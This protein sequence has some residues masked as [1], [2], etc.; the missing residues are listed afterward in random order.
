MTPTQNS[1]FPPK[2]SKFPLR[3]NSP[4]LGTTALEFSAEN[5]PTEIKLITKTGL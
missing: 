1:K 2:M 5:K 3:G 4:R